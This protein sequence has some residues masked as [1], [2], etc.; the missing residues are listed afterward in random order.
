[1]AL[2]SASGGRSAH[3]LRWQYASRVR[4]VLPELLDVSRTARHLPRRSV[5]GA[6]GARTRLRPATA[7]ASRENRLGAQLRPTGMGGPQLERAG[8][9]VLPEARS[10]ADGGLEDL[11]ADGRCADT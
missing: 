8:D 5:R 4:A 3:R 9:P 7:G 6:R 10:A 1:D 11:S 2:W